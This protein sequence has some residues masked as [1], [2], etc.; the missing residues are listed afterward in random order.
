MH[1]MIFGCGYSGTAIAKAFAG[2]D[3]QVSGT[4]RSAEKVE[5]L[6]A[7][8]IEAFLFDGE[9]M[10][11]RLSRALV[12]VTHLVQSIAP[13]K[14]DPLL[15]LLGEDS[16][17][18]LPRLEWIGYLSTVGVYGDHKGA[19]VSEET[20]CLPVSGRSKERLEAEEGWLAIG[21][22]RDVPAAIL[23][24]SGIYGPGR[25]AF[26]NLDKG[27]ARRLIKKDQVFNRIRVEDIGAAT[28]FLSEHGLGG[29]YNVTDDRPGPPQDVIV[30]AA[31]L[32]GVEPPPE[33]AFETAELTPMAR[34]FYGENKRVSNAKL[35]KAGFEFSFPTYPMSL[36]QLWQDGRWRG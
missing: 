27:T 23:R 13:G 12:D 18:L 9:T 21:R 1:V 8:G 11:D 17:R 24:L 15:R 6:R 33:Q 19:W 29:I 32:M 10:G 14:A 34:T 2:Q 30:E 4:T 28:R 7:N 3:V 16:A 35:K 22:E 36:A 31:R 26:C 5:A 20:P 25:N